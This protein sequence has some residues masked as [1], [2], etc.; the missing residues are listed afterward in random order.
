MAGFYINGVKI[1]SSPKTIESFDITDS[2]NVLENSVES[3]DFNKE[4]DVNQMATEANEEIS[5]SW[6]TKVKDWIIKLLDNIY[7]HIVSFVKAIINFFKNLINKITGKDQIKDANVSKDGQS[8]I[9]KGSFGMKTVSTKV[10]VKE[11]ENLMKGLE[12][13]YGMIKFI[14][15]QEYLKRI[16]ELYSY[17]GDMCTTVENFVKNIFILFLFMYIIAI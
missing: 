3:F 13:S 16:D 11:I 15:K 1:D 6:F 8:I 12:C 9:V 2:I 17:A 5:K 7:R 14:S 4:F 10:D